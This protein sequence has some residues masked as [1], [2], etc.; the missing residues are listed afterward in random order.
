MSEKLSL[1]F[2][3]ICLWKTYLGVLAS[4]SVQKGEVELTCISGVDL[5]RF[6]SLLIS[7]MPQET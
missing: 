3:V 5:A 4:L 1:I 2:Q 6:L 7:W